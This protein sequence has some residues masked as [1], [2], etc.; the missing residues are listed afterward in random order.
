MPWSL[1]A[2]VSLRVTDNGPGIASDV[3]PHVFDKFVRARSSSQAEGG[4]GSGLGLAIAKGVMDAH[5]GSI[6]AESPAAE[7]HGTRIV[8][9]F[10][11][12]EAPS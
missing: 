9:T 8:L 3:L 7:G 12:T 10:P 6:A 1:P 11:H 2:N 4:E 5:G